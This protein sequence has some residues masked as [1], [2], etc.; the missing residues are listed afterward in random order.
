MI[1]AK[2]DD[3]E[4]I[5]WNEARVVKH[6]EVK[7]VHN[8]EICEYEFI[9]DAEFEGHKKLVHINSNKILTEQEF[10][11]LNG[12]EQEDVRYGRDTPRRQDF[13]K[14]YILRKIY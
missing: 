12:V 14:R 2:C 7:H 9:G 10:D 13:M 8:C 1:E 3:C 4:D 6:K 11:E 5:G